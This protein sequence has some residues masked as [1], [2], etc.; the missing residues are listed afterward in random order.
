MDFIIDVIATSDQK[1]LLVGISG[2]TIYNL[3]FMNSEKK[4]WAY[5]LVWQKQQEE[6]SN[7]CTKHQEDWTDF[8]HKK[9]LLINKIWY[10]W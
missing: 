10:P 1:D 7:D 5:N 4:G 9:F 6:T 8:L 3:Q 2:L